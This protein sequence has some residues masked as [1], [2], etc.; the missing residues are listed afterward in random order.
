MSLLERPPRGLD[1]TQNDY[2]QMAAPANL[3]AG[4]PRLN[5]AELYKFEIGGGLDEARRGKGSACIRLLAGDEC[6]GPDD[7]GAYE[8]A[9]VLHIGNR[10]AGDAPDF[11][12]DCDCAASPLELW[13]HL[14]IKLVMNTVSTATMCRM[15][16]VIGNCMVWVS[17]SNK[18]LIDRGTRL[19]SRF[20][21]QGY[22]QACHALFRALEEIDRRR[23]RGEEV[24]SPVAAAIQ[25]HH[26][27]A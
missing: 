14:A 27:T 4:P 20:T 18:K 25:Q 24:P 2:E 16:R 3:L 5:N 23:D 19:V 11:H 9:R 1:W 7:R 15:N 8:Q 21:G 12:V 26:G 6:A 10:V 22:D 13:D 17:P